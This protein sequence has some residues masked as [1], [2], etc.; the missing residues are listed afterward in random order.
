VT[1]SHSPLTRVLRGGAWLAAAN[2]LGAVLLLAQG[3]VTTRALGATGLGIVAIVVAVVT[4]IRMLLSF[5]MGDVVVRYVA[6]ADARGDAAG[7]G[8]W[9]RLAARLEALTALLACGA[10]VL[11]G[12]AI[13]GWFVSR[14][15]AALVAA[16]AMTIP[17]GLCSE[18]AL[19]VLQVYRRFDL[20][21]L[22]HTVERAVSLAAAVTAA[23]QGWG[24][25][26]FVLAATVGPIVGSLLATL[27]AWRVAARRLGAGFARAGSVRGRAAEAV[28]FAA[29]TNLAASLSLVTK[30]AD[31]LWLGWLR[32]PA[33]AGLYK[34]AYNVATLAFQPVAP[35][36]QTVYPEAARLTAERRPDALRDLVA[37]ATRP[38]A[39]YGVVLLALAALFGETMLAALYGAEFAAANPALVVLILGIGVGAATFWARPVVLAHGGAGFALA[40]A[41]LGSAVK[42]AMVLLLVPRFGFAANA[43]GLT[44]AYLAGTALLVRRAQRELRRDARPVV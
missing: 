8:A 44:A 32:S 25:P 26:G 9:L 35:L 36:A 13:G 34:L 17:A 6:A 27:L 3:I 4:V 23:L 1:A 12:P 18:T 40:A 31:A 33:E 10:A 2:V 28:R 29:S 37:R 14:D 41:A 5:R 21:S 42:V 16:F 43:W 39:V 11:V 38:V 20:Q 22:V 15:H 30:D 7:A 19:G 24:I